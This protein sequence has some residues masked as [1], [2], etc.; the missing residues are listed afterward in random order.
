MRSVG[1]VNGDLY[2]MPGVLC[3]CSTMDCDIVRGVDN[4]ANKM[5]NVECCIEFDVNH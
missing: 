1:G 2:T 5:W 3:A 4:I